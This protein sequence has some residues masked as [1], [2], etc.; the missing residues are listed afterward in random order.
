MPTFEINIGQLS[1]CGHTPHCNMT[2]EEFI[3]NNATEAAS[4]IVGHEDDG[5]P[6]SSHLS[7]P[8]SF[9]DSLCLDLYH[10]VKTKTYNNQEEPIESTSINPSTI[11]NDLEL[12]VR[13]LFSENL[14]LKEK[15]RL[16][17][18]LK[19][20]SSQSDAE[21][22]ELRSQL[23]HQISL[24]DSSTMREDHL[25]RQILEFK[26][27]VHLVGI[28]LEHSR[29]ESEVF[30]SRAE[31]AEKDYE[32]SASALKKA[33]QHYEK[34][35]TRLVTEREEMKSSCE[36]EIQ[37]LRE[38]SNHE[39]N[40]SRSH[41][42]DAFARESKLLIDAR[43]QAI[44]QT[45]LLREEISELRADRETKAE[46]NADYTKELTRQLAD[47]RSELKVK[48]CELNTLQAIQNRTVVEANASK[49]EIGSI[50]EH[51]SLLQQDYAKLESERSRLEEINRQKDEAL[52]IYHHDDLL[53]D[54]DSENI[55]PNCQNTS[56]SGRKS[57]VKNQVALA[58]KCRDLQSLL[59]R[60]SVELSIEKEKLDIMTK[61]EE[62]NRRLFQDL[63]AQS[64]KNAST[65]IVSAVNARD[66]KI[67]KLSKKINSLQIDLSK[68]NHER[69]ELS[70]Q[71]AQVLERRDQLDEM[72]GLVASLR[73]A[74][75]ASSQTRSA[76]GIDD[77]GI[78]E[79]DTDLFEHMVHRSFLA[80]Q[81]SNSKTKP[82]DKTEHNTKAN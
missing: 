73:R 11:N 61:K 20:R 31:K 64:N 59:K 58:R 21:V 3:D 6:T 67:L 17:D 27:K 10:Q 75:E 74:M 8:E 79:E 29:K 43:D 4:P 47:A 15:A 54:C 72:K 19:K 25:Q 82:K 14:E 48:C 71:L 39:I 70:S 12:K 63:T 33:Q 16:Y 23:Q 50:K 30:L 18:A 80:L 53:V 40:S 81:R 13:Q 1:V 42:N 45:K 28:D 49:E 66:D 78:E 24:N 51:L 35:L 55:D 68:V 76:E 32:D 57:L 36:K 26:R 5:S 77:L 65:Y 52:Q 60:Q 56:F 22:E 9:D 41:L 44:E 2:I 34:E 38:S 37:R 7:L 69:D 62:S 46:E